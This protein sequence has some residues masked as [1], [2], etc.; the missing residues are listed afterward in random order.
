MDVFVG[1]LK[2]FASGLG[3]D[4]VGVARA[5]P[6]D[7]FDRYREWLDRGYAGSMEY[8]HAHADARRSPQ[9]VFAP[10]RSVVMAASPYRQP[11]APTSTSGR[12]G[13]V[14]R[15]AAGGDYHDWLREKL[16]QL[17]AWMEQRRPES[18]SRVIVDTAPLLERDFARRAGLGWFG[19]NTMLINKY[20]GSY[21]LL[22][23]VLTD[24][25]LPADATHES[26][27][28]GSCTRCLEACPTGAF[29]AAGWLDARRCI[30]Y[31]TIEH[32]GPIAAEFRDGIGD[33]LFG[34]DIC[35][36]VCPWNRK[37]DAPSDLIDPREL[38]RLDDA[39]FRRRFRGTPLFRTKRRGVLRNAAIVLGNVGGM[40]DLP[41]LRAAAG[42]ADDDVREAAAWAL[43][44]IQARSAT[45][46]AGDPVSDAT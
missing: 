11:S 12:G 33:W 23:A 37:A 43:G 27:H 21:L 42:D 20:R 13:Q 32:K 18:R 44:R 17:A 10:V 6:A 35:Q 24:L 7:G 39:E 16:K 22:G 25:D 26:A 40:D 34:C 45:G 8:L 29:P 30:S 14:A 5:D 41:V 36:E 31:L 15:Y 28:C 46:V 9:S 1:E 2:A 4:P 38:L 3:L 19:K